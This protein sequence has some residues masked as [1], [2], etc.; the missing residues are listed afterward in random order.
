MLIRSSKKRKGDNQ[1][2]K[3]NG[4]KKRNCKNSRSPS[5]KKQKKRVKLK[6]Q[7]EIKA[8]AI[9]INKTNRTNRNKGNQTRRKDRAI[10]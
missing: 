6:A 9:P 4:C 2:T 8:V 3:T 5:V 7:K 1:A 10:L